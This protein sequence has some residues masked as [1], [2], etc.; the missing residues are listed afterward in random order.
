MT[1]WLVRAGQHGEF[2]QKFLQDNKIYVTWNHLAVDLSQ[3]TSKQQLFSEMKSIYSDAKEKALHNNVSQIWPFAHVMEHGDL[4]VMPSK[5]QRAI[6][7]AQITGDYTFVKEG[8]SPFFHYRAVKWEA[9]PVPRS[10]FGQDLLHSFGAFMT[11]CRITRNNA[12]QRLA[13]MRKDGW[14]PE[15]VEE[16]T[17]AIPTVDDTITDEASEVSDIEDMARDQ[18][19]K[20]IEAKF[21][22][23]GLTRLVDAILRAQGYTTYVSPEGSDGGVD[24][25]AGS[26]PLGFGDRRI[27]VEVKS[28]TGPIDRPTVDKLL[29]AMTKFHA[30][31]CLFVSWSGYKK[32][33]Q[34]EMAPSFFNLRLWTQNEIFDALFT[35]YEKLDAEIKADLPLKRIWTVALPDE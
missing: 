1:V 10:N 32:N 2:E 15:R 3:L 23:H 6:W 5:M 14:K 31:E 17:K 34:K 35:H 20:L 27:C 26:S 7:V 4:V 8:P 16:I 11:I 19:S 13:A 28:E 21:A 24:I 22:G 33:V 29:G 30:Q 25:L 12:V 9:E 18:I